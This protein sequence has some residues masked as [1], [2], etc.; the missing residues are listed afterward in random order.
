LRKKK[1]ILGVFVLLLVA[2]LGAP[3]KVGAAEIPAEFNEIL[4]KDGYLEVNSIPPTTF[5][6]AYLIID[7]Y[8][9]Y[10]RTE[11]RFGLEL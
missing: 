3:K 5:E 7:D 10:E 1:I 6:Q 4:S 2:I 9:L 8:S 11:G